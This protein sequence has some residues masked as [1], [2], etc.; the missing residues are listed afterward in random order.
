MVAYMAAHG[1][2]LPTRTYKIPEGEPGA[3]FALGAWVAD[4]RQRRGVSAARRAVLDATEGWAWAR[5]R[6]E[7]AAHWDAMRAKAAR[8]FAE[9]GEK[10]PSA[11]YVGPVDG[12]HVG[13]W[14][15]NQRKQYK[16]GRGT[17]PL[18]PA[19]VAKLE[20]TPGWLWGAKIGVPL[21]DREAHWDAMLAKVIRCFAERGA[22][23]LAS[24]RDSVDGCR[25]GSWVSVQRQLYKGNQPGQSL[26]PAR[27]AKLEATPGWLWE[28]APRLRSA[29]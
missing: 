7:L 12:S 27:V 10:W 13:L 9:H 23:P 17:A 3:G 5:T 20:A 22:W 16:G 2:A 1:G 25:V 24:Y 26:S 11:R 29:E 21:A 6:S 8:H 18:S 14:V 28:A 4:Q 15:Q 19:R